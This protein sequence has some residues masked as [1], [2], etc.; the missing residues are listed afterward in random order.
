M[1]A[2]VITALATAAV[3]GCVWG[4]AGYI[5]NKLK[6]GTTSFEPMLLV[7]PAVVGAVFGVWALATN[8]TVD[9]VALLPSAAIVTP[10]AE[11]LLKIVWRAGKKVTGSQPKPAKK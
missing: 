2:E 8:S 9:A 10:F 7:L 11:A 4:V 3:G 1:I 5:K 6:D